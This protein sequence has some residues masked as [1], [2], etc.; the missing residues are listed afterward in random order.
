MGHHTC[1]LGICTISACT[2]KGPRVLVLPYRYVL[3]LTSTS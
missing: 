3:M 2:T 1:Y